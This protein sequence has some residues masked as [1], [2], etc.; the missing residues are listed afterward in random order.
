MK[1]SKSGKG[2]ENP[3]SVEFNRLSGSSEDLGG[4][5]YFDLLDDDEPSESLTVVEPKILQNKQMNLEKNVFHISNVSNEIG[6]K[7]SNKCTTKEACLAKPQSNEVVIS[8][9]CEHNGGQ[10]KERD[11]Y[12]QGGRMQERDIDSDDRRMIGRDCNYDGGRI[13][14]RDR[15]NQGRRMQERDGDCDGRRM[16]GRDGDSDG[17]RIIERDRY[18]QGGRM[19]ERD[20]DYDYD[21]CN[22]GGRVGRKDAREE[23]GENDG[24]RVIRNSQLQQYFEMCDFIEMVKMRNRFFPN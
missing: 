21:R 18:N 1:K 11:H 13:I 5:S 22:Y 24:R 2:K 6:S 19:P 4:S 8:N 14:E 10:M 12:N 16:M 20:R 7:S 3:Y 17:R 9:T 15:Y 23:E